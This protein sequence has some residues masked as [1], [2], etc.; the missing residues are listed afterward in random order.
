MQA[1]TEAKSQMEQHTSQKTA[2]CKP[3]RTSFG[4]DLKKDKQTGRQ[5]K[6]TKLR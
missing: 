5:T 3:L 6:N 1:H 2:S 4:R